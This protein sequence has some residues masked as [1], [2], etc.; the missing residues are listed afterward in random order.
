MSAIEGIQRA[1]HIALT[2]LVEA[3]GSSPDAATGA[4]G[5]GMRKQIAELASN[6]SKIQQELADVRKELVTLHERFDG[7]D[8]RVNGRGV[9]GGLP[10]RGSV[11]TSVGAVIGGIMG[12]C[13]VVLEMLKMFGLLK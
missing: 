12:T 1:D 5:R 13:A 8:E 11:A 6:T 7:R 9:V 3:V 2:A 4:E 10:P